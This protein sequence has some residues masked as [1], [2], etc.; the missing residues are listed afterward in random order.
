MATR[1]TVFD[2]KNIVITGGAGFLGSHL[3]DQLVQRHKVI[4]IDNFSTG[5]EQNIHHLLSN[6]NFEFVRHDMAEPIDLASLRELKAFQVPFQGIQE[7]Y[8]LAS[9]SSPKDYIKL[10]T[11]TLLANSLGT[12]NALDLAKQFSAKFLL[13]SS[14]SIYGEPVEKTP[15]PENYFGY[16]NPIGIRSPYQEGKRFAEALTVA[17]RD[18][19]NLEAKIIRLFNTYGPRMRFNDG[20]MIPEFIGMAMKNMPMIIRGAKEDTATYCFVTDAIEGLTRMMAS[21]EVGPMNIGHPEEHTIGQIADQIIALTGSRP[22]IRVEPALASDAKQATPSVRQA[23]E[24]LGWFPVVPLEEG[25]RR[26]IE[27]MRGS[28]SVSL[29]SF[30]YLPQ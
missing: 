7:I 14:S 19:F 23:R 15:F 9:P 5:D 16:V 25:L 18:R 8:H 22:E 12:K 28:R 24:V 3:C 2:K 27:Y 17:Y 13:A 1:S 29:E 20:R 26:T 4:C 6:P 21:K 10:T 30:G 11:E